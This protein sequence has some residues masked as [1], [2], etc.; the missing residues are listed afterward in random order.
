[1]R[2]YELQHPQRVLSD[3]INKL[4]PHEKNEE[5]ERKNRAGSEI[6]QTIY[7]TIQN[8]RA[9]DL[10]RELFDGLKKYT[11]QDLSEIVAHSLQT[12]V[13]MNELSDTI[14]LELLDLALTHDMQELRKQ[15]KGESIPFSAD[16]LPRPPKPEV[17]LAI[18][19]GMRRELALANQQ[20]T[21]ITRKTK[22]PEQST[23]TRVQTAL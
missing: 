15:I 7:S 20:V 16:I 13:S 18:R 9:V 19:E 22:V 2:E 4:M 6:L 23:P 17:R 11:K 8:P 5:A 3:V 21:G 1:M 10:P 12:E 14:K